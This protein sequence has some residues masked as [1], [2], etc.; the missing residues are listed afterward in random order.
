MADAVKENPDMEEKPRGE[1]R[2]LED[3]DSVDK[4]NSSKL[5]KTA[6]TAAKGAGPPTED[7]GYTR[8]EGEPYKKKKVVLLMMYSG[9]NY[10]GMQKNPGAHTIESV[11]LDGLCKAGVIR[12]IHVENPGKMLHFQRAARTDK[13]VSAAGQVV[14][15]Q[16]FVDVENPLEKI[17]ENL[18]PEIR[19]MGIQRVTRKFCSKAA[20]NARTY[21]YMLPTFSFTPVEQFTMESYRITDEILAEVNKTLSV[22]K[23]THNFH[24]FT[25]GKKH[26]EASAKRYIMDF[27][28][29]EPFMMKN[30]QYAVITVKGQSFMLHQIRKMIGL[31]IAIVKGL[32][33][34]E[35]I[36][37]AWGP[38]KCD[39]PKAPGLGLMLDRVHYDYYNKRF[40]TD[41]QHEPIE[42]DKYKDAIQKFK[43]ENIYPTVI[44]TE[45]KEKSMLEW[46]GTLHLHH[47]DIIQE[48]ENPD[49]RKA[50]GLQAKLRLDQA[51]AAVQEQIQNSKLEA[52]NGS[53]TE[54]VKEEDKVTSPEALPQKCDPDDGESDTSKHQQMEVCSPKEGNK[55][56]LDIKV[57]SAGGDQKSSI[58]NVDRSIKNV[59]DMSKDDTV[60]KEPAKPT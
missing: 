44:E 13:G 38:L 14:S 32:T 54:V 53:E 7:K 30:V 60:T 2:S 25:S 41:G 28:I 15:L 24:N 4:D 23:G 49:T 8:E 39:I 47:F 6:A 48:H 59:T 34:P 46:L 19:V 1:K 18:P 17:N 12:Q 21:M 22:F 57:E 45:E 37:K 3:A 10:M 29:G 9:K 31:T 50:A 40:G 51:R 43:E 35:V 55:N 56:D 26:N 27:K 58:N 33:G 16:M 36:T 52:A 5:L 11:L 42:W 20:A